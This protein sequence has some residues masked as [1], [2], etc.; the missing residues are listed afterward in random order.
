MTMDVME[1]STEMS[2]AKT[3]SAGIWIFRVL[4]VAAAGVMLVSWFMPWVTVDIEALGKGIIEIRPWGLELDE[5]LG[6]FEI[7]L[8]GADMP[9]WFAPLMWA[10]LGICMVA[11]LVGAWI[12]GVEVE[13]G[14]FKIKL[15]KLLVGGVGFSYFI[16]GIV[17]V[18][19][20]SMRCEDCMGIP[21]LGRHFVDLGDPLVTYVEG[22]LLPGYFLIYVAAIFLIALAFLRDKIVGESES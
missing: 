17:A 1:T 19:Y 22:R 20:G 4:V 21:L 14:N 6:G 9:N 13:I 8:K 5:R 18:V 11:L 3:S 7:L 15:S 16:A 2:D 12:R 10:Y